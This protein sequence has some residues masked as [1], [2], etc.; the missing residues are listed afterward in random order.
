MVGFS[1]AAGNALEARIRQS[2]I[3]RGKTN[4][5]TT[6]DGRW[7]RWPDR[8]VGGAGREE[9]PETL[10]RV[11]IREHNVE[12]AAHLLRSTNFDDAP[13]SGL[14]KKFSQLFT[15]N[16]FLVHAARCLNVNKI[17]TATSHFRVDFPTGTVAFLMIATVSGCLFGKHEHER[18]TSTV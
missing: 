1:I 8:K 18:V 5:R 13:A 4:L 7:I 14:A 3:V 9:S 17:S 12:D 11:S 15:L 16:G 10:A 6:H 2:G